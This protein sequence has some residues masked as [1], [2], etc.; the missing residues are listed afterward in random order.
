MQDIHRTRCKGDGHH[1]A[2]S[3]ESVVDLPRT[4]SYHGP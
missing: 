4:T 1:L 2:A 3:H